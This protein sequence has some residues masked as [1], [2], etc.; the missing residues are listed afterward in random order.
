MDLSAYSNALNGISAFDIGRDKAAKIWGCSRDQA[1]RILKK[2][3]ATSIPEI[4]YYPSPLSS[5]TVKAETITETKDS[6][7]YEIPNTR[8]ASLEELIDK[9]KVDTSKWD[10]ERFI[11]NRWQV[12]AKNADGD[13]VVEPLY[14]IKAWFKRAKGWNLDSVNKEIARIKE[15][16]KKSIAPF[17][18]NKYAKYL[19]DSGLCLE[20]NI[21]DPHIAKLAWSGETG[22][23]DYDSKIAASMVGKAFESLVHRP[24]YKISKVLIV[25][26]NDFYNC[27]G[28]TLQTTNGTPQSNDSRYPKMFQIG[29]DILSRQ[30][31]S[32]LKVAPVE[33]M[34]CRG[35]HDSLSMWHAGHSLECLYSG[36]PHVDI[37]N[38]PLM[39][40]YW[41]YGNNMVMFTHG[42]SPKGKSKNQS[43]FS[44]MP[45]EAPEMWVSSRYREIHLGHLHQYRDENFE[46]T[47]VRIKI[48]PSLTPPDYWHYTNGYCGNVRAAQAFEWSMCDG[49]VG[50]REFSVDMNQ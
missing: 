6:L 20:V 39:R 5:S 27:D 44:L 34:I 13:I 24:G 9:F 21:A 33:V 38:S 19:E 45:L 42:D 17:N 50:T 11:C 2:L 36:S 40:K 31:E 46:K 14:Q 49:L 7:S 23:A 1:R 15:Q 48:V 8:I 4:D 29:F 28:I 37:N 22:H 30:V 18:V 47:G 25:A 43:L 3:R 12:G 10:C 41:Q 16:A 35:N 26:G 32:A